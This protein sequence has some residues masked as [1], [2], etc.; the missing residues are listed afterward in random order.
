MIPGFEFKEL[1]DDE[2][3]AREKACTAEFIRRDLMPI[4][5]AVYALESTGELSSE[6]WERG[7]ERHEWAKQE[8]FAWGHED[9]TEVIAQG[10][11][12]V[13]SCLKMFL[14]DYGYKHEMMSNCPFCLWQDI[15]DK[16]GI[17]HDKVA[18]PYFERERLTA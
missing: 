15:T 14:A 12:A 10:K 7:L 8:N 4:A 1:S 16:Y 17:D 6:V 9:W 2:Y 11:D 18:L 3:A 13:I 5:G